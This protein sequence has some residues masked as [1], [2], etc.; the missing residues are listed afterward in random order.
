MANYEKALNEFDTFNPVRNLWRNVLIVAISDAIK[1]KSVYTDNTTT[2]ER[3]AATATEETLMAIDVDL[4]EYPVGTSFKL[5]ASFSTAANGN[6]KTVKLVVDGTSVLS[7]AS[8]I[9][10]P[11]GLFGVMEST[12][13][14]LDTA[15]TVAYST[16]LVG[17]SQ[18]VGI[19]NTLDIDWER[20]ITVRV[21]VTAASAVSDINLYSFQV[22]PLK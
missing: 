8:A 17:T 16:E 20:T 22:I 12:I 9:A 21:D 10:A 7:S 5:I 14:H 13:L 19:S 6:T 3:V 1:V 2:G 18:A 4:R 15:K 11:N